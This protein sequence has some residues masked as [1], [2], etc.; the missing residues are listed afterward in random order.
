MLDVKA[1]WI[2]ALAVVTSL[3]YA[4]TKQKGVVRK[5]LAPCDY[6][7][8]IK[9]FVIQKCARAG[10]HVNG[11]PFGDFTTYNDLKARADNGKLK[12]LALELRLMPPA[13]SEPL[14]SEEMM[15]LECWIEHG[16]T[17]D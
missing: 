14:S 10:C 3:L 15:K 4:C 1:V 11:F 2:P 12:S 16:A 9:P 7:T 13:T 8:G 6:T 17:D 5:E